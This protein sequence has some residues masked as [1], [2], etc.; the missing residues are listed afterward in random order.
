[1]PF[2]D[3]LITFIIESKPSE[4]FGSWEKHE[5]VPKRNNMASNLG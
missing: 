4:R 3:L 2:V 5:K 1:M